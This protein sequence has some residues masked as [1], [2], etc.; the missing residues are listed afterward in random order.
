[1]KYISPIN[2]GNYINIMYINYT[3]SISYT[4]YDDYINAISIRPTT[5]G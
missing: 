5:A 3:D 1:M 2:Y 4:K